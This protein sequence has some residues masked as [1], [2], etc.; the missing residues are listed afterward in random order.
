MIRSIV[1]SLFCILTT[2]LTAQNIDDLQSKSKIAGTPHNLT[3]NKNGLG[4]NDILT[5]Y[6][7]CRSCHVPHKTTAVEP[8][9]YRKGA[10][11]NFDLNKELD[12]TNTHVHPLDPGSRKCLACHDGS[13]ARSFPH[14]GELQNPQ[15][16]LTAPEVRAPANYNM[17]LFNFPSSG[18][19]ISRPGDSSPLVLN[20]QNEV[21][22]ITCHDPHNNEKGHFLRV[23]NQRSEICLECHH[24]QNWELSTHGNAQNP[25]HA[26]L[27]E[28]ACL[29][30]HEIH[31]LPTNAKLLRADENTLCL[32]CHDGSSDDSREIASI[33][34]LEEVFEKTFTHPIRINPN[35]TGVGYGSTTDSPWNFGLA[36]DR[37][38]RCGDC[39]NP[40]AVSG[41]NIS[42]VLDGS[43]AFVKGVDAIGFNKDQAEFEYEVCYKC[44]GQ[45]Q[46]VKSG[47]DVARLFSVGNRSFHPVENLGL[48]GSVP[49]L[50][51]GWS[52]QSL[53]TCSDCHGN[54]DKY[55]PQGPHGSSIPHILS[56]PYSDIPFGGLG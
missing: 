44:H 47:N 1:L 34:N 48:S 15:V 14:R 26:E 33:K 32:S 28:V 35:V 19:E 29:Q 18:R 23:S 50:K 17:H 56:A 8:L 11:P 37:F 2:F 53:I 12:V 4:T 43:L 10:I 46:N 25:L 45:N 13:M 16:N 3:Q 36:N 49:S 9:W 6:S 31:T 41:K 21:S 54:D 7:F 55:G 39:H 52:E 27:E 30:C 22:C 42:P 40:H 5:D 24:M 38:V 51:P 20:S